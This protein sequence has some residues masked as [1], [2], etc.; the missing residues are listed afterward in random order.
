M[1]LAPVATFLASALLLVALL[2][3]TAPVHAQTPADSPPPPRRWL[4]DATA[5][6]PLLADP[7]ETGFRGS[8][9]VAGGRGFYDGTHAEAEVAFG[10]RVPLVRLRRETARGPAVTLAFETGV[11]SRFFLAM[12]SDLINADFRVGV[13]VALRYGPWAARAEVRHISSHLGDDFADRFDVPFDNVSYESVE[14]LLARSIGAVRLYGGG[15]YH[16]RRSQSVEQGSVRAGLEYDA[17]RTRPEAR[18]WPFAAAALRAAVPQ[19]T[20]RLAV[21]V[22]AGVGARVGGVQFRAELR[23][24]AGA[25]PLGQFRGRDELFAGLGLRILQ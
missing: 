14:L 19:Q 11:F 7:L 24:H 3:W 13:P 6:A 1:P 20:N 5:F 12:P 16:Y 4:P 18:A 23:A 22:A 2:L 10:E 17:L 21:T 9:V 15:A 8:L 25:T